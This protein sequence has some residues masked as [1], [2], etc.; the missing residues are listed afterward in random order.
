MT[1]DPLYPVIDHPDWVDRLGRAGAKL[2]Q[3]RMKDR[4]EPELRIAIRASLSLARKYAMTLVVNDH[5]RLALDERAEWLHLGQEDLDTADLAA[6]RSGGLKLG[7]STHDEAELDRALA[8]HP[9]Y[10]ALGP[11]FPTKLK[12]L[13]FGPQGLQRITLWKE[14]IAAATPPGQSPPPLVAIGGIT[15]ETAR[16]CLDHGA[17]SVAIVTDI[18]ASQKPEARARA[19]LAV[20]RPRHGDASSSSNAS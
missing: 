3:L 15:L 10:V 4:P 6:I 18:L 14:K 19:L 7:I 1:I 20:T 17:D 5:W 13:R 11:I 16:Q 12:V 8:L 2:I 9:D